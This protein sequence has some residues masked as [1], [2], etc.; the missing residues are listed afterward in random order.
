V[1]AVVVAVVVCVVGGVGAPRAAAAET[2]AVARQHRV[3][4]DLG[5]ASAI[6]LAGVGYQFAPVPWLRLEGGVG[7]GPTG[8]Q[9]SIMP[10]IAPNT[11]RVCTFTTGVGAALAVGGVQAEEGPGHGPHPD[12]LPWLNVDAA[13]IECRLTNGLSFQGALGVT[14]PLADFHYD[15]VDTGDTIRAG[16][17]LPQGRTGIGWWF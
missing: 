14:L 13:G 5:V 3:G 11:T 9:F 4:I 10:K 8:T 16:Q 7:W 12:P 15:F 6:G 2:T 17:L 1:R